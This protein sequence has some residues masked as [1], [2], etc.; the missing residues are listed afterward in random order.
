MT[1]LLT[2]WICGEA[3]NLNDCKTDERGLPV[4][5]NC[6]AARMV[7]KEN[8]QSVATPRAGP[9]EPNTIP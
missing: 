5:G 3:V 9:Q 6:Y 8:Q 2:C 4:H 1:K 7:A